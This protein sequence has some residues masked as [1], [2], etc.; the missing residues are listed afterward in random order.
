[1]Q[2]IHEINN[3]MISIR[4]RLEELEM[5]RRKELSRLCKSVTMT[6]NGNNFEFEFNG[7]K[8]KGIKYTPKSD[9]YVKPR[10]K[11]YK[12]RNLVKEF[13]EGKDTSDVRVA[14]ALGDLN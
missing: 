8:F 7:T 12:G 6:Q 5:L 4:S 14:I 3:E 9:N 2:T 11:L 10:I 13:P 1:M